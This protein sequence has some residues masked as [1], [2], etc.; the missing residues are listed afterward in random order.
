[1]GN[2]FFK[3]EEN[4]LDFPF[5]NGKPSV[6][7]IGWAVLTFGVILTIAFYFGLAAYIPG[8]EHWPFPLAAIVDI[9]IILIPLA[10]CCKGKLGLIIKMPKLKDMKVVILCAI[11]YLVSTMA[12]NMILEMFGVVG[13][14]NPLGEA[15]AAAPLLV[16]V[17]LLVSLFGE[18]LFKIT[19]F[20]IVMAAAYH[21]TKNRKNSIIV[22]IV[23][24]CILFGLIHMP[25]Y[26]F[27]IAQCMLLIGIGCVFHIC[28]YVKTKNIVNSYI[29]HLMIDFVIFLPFMIIG[30][31]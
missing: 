14:S 13:T 5:Y 29:T 11:A 10:Y 6:S 27:N 18:E 2:D 16:T 22:G 15:A 23:G 17:D 12:I 9:L 3:F 25:T 19:I 7:I 21:V 1:M 8:Y 24:A 4:D 28:P 20:L 26:D 30:A 31:M